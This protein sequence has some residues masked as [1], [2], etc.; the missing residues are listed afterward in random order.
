MKHSILVQQLISYM[1]LALNLC[2]KNDNK[3]IPIPLQ[4]N[5]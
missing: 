2:T 4:I 3:R 1:Q 5:T